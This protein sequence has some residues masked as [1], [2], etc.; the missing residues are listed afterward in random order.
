MTT[1]KD[2]LPE[3]TLRD[4]VESRNMLQTLMNREMSIH[5]GHRLSKIFRKSTSEVKSYQEGVVKKIESFEG[6]IRAEDGSV[7]LDPKSAT[8]NADYLALE[9]VRNEALDKAVVLEGCLTITLKEL[10]ESMPKINVG[11]ADD[12]KWEEEKIPPVIYTP[13]WWAI[14]HDE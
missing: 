14:T 4:V 6:Y 7:K 5:V 11:T 8:Y 13:L 1:K 2:Q 10:I 12:P 3:I 9:K